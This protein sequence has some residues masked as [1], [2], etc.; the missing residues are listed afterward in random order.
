MT[1]IRIVA[2]D[3]VD[4]FCTTCRREVRV[5]PSLA[6]PHCGTQVHPL[7][8]PVVPKSNGVISATS[9]ETVSETA[10]TLSQNGGGAQVA[11]PAIREATAWA[12]S[13]DALIVALEREEAEALAAYEAA[14]KRVRD[15]RRSA[16]AMRQ[17]RGMVAVEQARSAL[18]PPKAT[19]Q[20]RKS[21][22]VTVEASPVTN[23]KGS[24]RLG[25]EHPSYVPETPGAQPAQPERPWS[26]QYAACINCGTTGRKSGTTAHAAKGRCFLC[27]AYHVKHGTERPPELWSPSVGSDQ[28]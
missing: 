4:A 3:S 5:G 10:T 9:S 27:Y 13:T 24:V 2:R 23:G 26:R 16:A 14:R 12:A 28:S 17:L 19:R 22:T 25:P 6:C 21:R 7:S 1:N 11:L 20:G 8:L 18:T 15:A